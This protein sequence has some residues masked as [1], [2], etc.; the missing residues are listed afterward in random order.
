[1][2]K[3]PPTLGYLTPTLRRRWGL[4]QWILL[5]IGC[6]FG[7]GIVYFLAVFF[8]LTSGLFDIAG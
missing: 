8:V 3:P 1:M 5:V 7:L 2:E 6:I 4:R